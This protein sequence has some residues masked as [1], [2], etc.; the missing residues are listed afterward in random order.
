MAS[1]SAAPAVN[2]DFD[3]ATRFRRCRVKVR[4]PSMSNLASRLTRAFIALSAM[5][6]LASAPA[7]LVSEAAS[8]ETRSEREREKERESSARV[9]TITPGPVAGARVEIQRSAVVN[10]AELARLEALGLAP[11]VP[12][13]RVRVPRAEE[14]NE[15]DIE[16]GANIMG[17]PS[18]ESMVTPPRFGPYVV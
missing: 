1:L 18:P 2:R 10:L 6:V 8:A 16:P 11:N 14:E 9:T 5:F 17:N 12:I 15:M 4:R 3:H 7:R 13:V